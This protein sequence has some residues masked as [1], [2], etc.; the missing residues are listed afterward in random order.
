[1]GLN[2]P[3][4]LRPGRRPQSPLVPGGVLAIDAGNS[5]TDVALVAADGRVLGAARGGG[6]QPPAVGIGPATAALA[7]I[8]ARAAADAGFAVQEG[9]GDGSRPLAAYTSA[10]L[11]NADLPIEE[12]RL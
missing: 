10:C 2:S 4:S 11:A 5:K 3:Q 7:E 6:F 1:V 9:G 8:V 12:Q